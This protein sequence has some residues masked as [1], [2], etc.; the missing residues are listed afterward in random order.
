M[1]DALN[2]CGSTYST[3]LMAPQPPNLHRLNGPRPGLEHGAS[4]T[5][6]VSKILDKN[7]TPLPRSDTSFDYAC[8][9]QADNI[10]SALGQ[11]SH[12]SPADVAQRKS[13]AQRPHEGK[14]A[15]MAR[16][17]RKASARRMLGPKARN[18]GAPYFT[19][20]STS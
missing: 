2:M 4:R 18:K 15:G 9:G 17:R 13:C 20:A 14:R 5:R 8:A 3:L 12:Q 16:S 7:V 10:S 6:S 1:H 11:L 19:V